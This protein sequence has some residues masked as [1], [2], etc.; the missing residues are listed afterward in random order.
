MAQTPRARTQLANVPRTL[1][2]VPTGARTSTNHSQLYGFPQSKRQQRGRNRK[3]N[4]R[5]DISRHH[6]TCH[7]LGKFRSRSSH[8]NEPTHATDSPGNT[9]KY[10]H[11]KRAPKPYLSSNQL[12]K[13]TEKHS[14][15][16]STTSWVSA[17]S[18]TSTHTHPCS[19]PATSHRS[20]PAPSS[21][22]LSTQQ[23]GSL[24]VTASIPI[25]EQPPVPTIPKTTNK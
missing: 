4:I 25:A 6:C 12:V 9:T 13:S 8:S 7:L 16:D 20:I 10:P 17:P 15:A 11:E 24:P 14:S 21:S 5:Q 22:P 1:Q 3:Q 19:L 18:L 2:Q 23:P